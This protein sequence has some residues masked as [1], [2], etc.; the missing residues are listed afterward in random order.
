MTQEN[1]TLQSPGP[2]G[3]LAT[4]HRHWMRIACALLVV[5]PSLVVVGPSLALAQSDDLLQAYQ[6]YESAK[7]RERVP[8]ALKFGNDALKLTEAEG[9][10]AQ[11]L[12]QL[13]RNLAEFAAQAGQDEQ[14]VGYLE[15]ALT[16][17]EADLGPD[18]PDLVPLLSALA[19]LHVK[20]KRYSLAEALLQRMLK[21]ERAAFGDYHENVLATLVK[22]QGVY[23]ATNNVDAVAA[24]DA[25]L[26]VPPVSKRGLWG[27]KGGVTVDSKRYG[28]KNGFASV[29]VFYG[30]NR[31][32]TGNEKPALRYGKAS[33]PLQYGYL[34]VT[35]PQTHKFAELETP[36]Q[37]SEYTLSVR[38]TDLRSQFVLLDA[39]QPLAKDDFVRELQQ[40][41]KSSPSKDVFIFV[42]GYNNSF[43]D[44]AR[45]AAQ[46][47][48]DLD[49][50]G[51]PMMYS[52]P[53][54]A[55]LTG[56][57]ADES[58]IE[59]SG[60][61]MAEFLRTVAAQTGGA[62]IHV[63]AHS[64]GN[65][66]LLAALKGYLPTL[67]QDKHPLPF[68]QLV[69]TAPDVDRKVFMAT[70][71]SLRGVAERLTLYAS[72]SDVALRMSRYYHGEPRAGSAG[73]LVIRLQGLDTIDMSGLPADVLG[74]SYFAA[75]GGAVYDLLRLL[76]RGDAPDSPQRCSTGEDSAGNSVV[77]WR[78]NVAKCQGSELLEA[79]MLLKEYR[80][81]A[82]AQI[83]A[84]V[85][86]QISALTEPSQ[87]R[88]AQMILDRLNTLLA[89]AGQP[90]G[91]LAR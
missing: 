75:N 24:I 78:F 63:I 17:Q 83:V 90:A 45:R 19:D 88:A 14:A 55:S 76:W 32:P 30:T 68:G 46:L 39:V 5:G 16:L 18:H 79:A 35:I 1:G 77:I 62:R 11:E 2:P 42:H 26:Q 6:Q 53:S 70:F 85:S 54:Q 65:R 71:P 59:V 15:R 7:T 52:W 56:Y 50:D 23:R 80:D 41:I 82:S 33:G 66:V 28:L 44:T 29:R 48:Y 9:G 20:A 51:T 34:D 3:C 64:M 22:L 47:A 87:R 58:M 27:I 60:Q 25:Q 69:F 37:W 4:A 91:E 74:H 57:A 49:F 73:A 13:L 31:T 81:E 38:K 67:A 43:E 21:I 8:E 72:D 10:S 36:K 61:R 89:S 86:A 84:Q 40:E 12:E